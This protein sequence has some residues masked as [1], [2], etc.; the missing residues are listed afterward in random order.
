M[1]MFTLMT[2]NFFMHKHSKILRKHFT[3]IQGFTF[4]ILFILSACSDS[5]NSEAWKAESGNMSDKNLRASMITALEKHIYIGMPRHK[6]I[7]LLG[8]SDIHEPN[9]D[10]YLLGTSA[11]GVDYEYYYIYYKNNKVI[12]FLIVQG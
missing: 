8:S 6:I 3:F 11:Y 10:I 4:C 5:F 12:K 9:A 2:I 1:E 7:E